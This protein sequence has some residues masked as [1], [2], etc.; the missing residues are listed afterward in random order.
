MT[1]GIRPRALLTLWPLVLLVLAACRGEPPEPLARPVMVTQPVPAAGD[2]SLFA[3][4][5]VAHDQ[6]D[7]AFRVAG[8][9]L[10]RSV[11]VG[12]RV[13]AGQVL[14]ELDPADFDLRV[15]AAGAQ[16]ASAQAEYSLAQ[17]ELERYQTLRERRLVSQSELDSR[18]TRFEG[19]EARVAEAEAQL[20]VARNQLDYTRLLAPADGAVVERRAD[21]GQVVAAGQT[22]FVLAV[23]G[24]REIAISLSERDIGQ[25]RIGQQVQVEL[26]ARPGRRVAGQIDELAPEAD[27]MGRTYA[28]RIA[29]DSAAIDAE[30]G[31]SARVLIAR[32]QDSSLALPLPAVTRFADAPFVWVLAPDG[33]SVTR[34]EVT[35]ASFDEQH[36]VVSGG[37]SA[38]DWVVAAG[39]ALLQEGQR[40]KPVDRE[41]RPITLVQGQ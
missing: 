15:Q 4:A 37:L 30:L 12:Q 9:I 36:A 41:N 14:A 26:W 18:Q 1:E 16:L 6:P 31:Q 33:G 5:V 39:A 13:R 29:F 10:R 38:S 11:D 40:V 27:A 35:V 2:W 24:P 20:A 25:F 23:D 3:G 7:L 19:A 17:A 32:S 8:R 22:V 28:A 21:A 34:R